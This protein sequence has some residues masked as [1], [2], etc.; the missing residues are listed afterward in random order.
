MLFRTVILDGIRK[1]TV[2][3]AFRRWKRPTVKPGGSLKTAAGVLA[4]AAVE[5]IREDEINEEDARRA[6]AASRADL[7]AEL[8]KSGSGTLYRI[9]FRR[10]GDDPRLALREDDGLDHAAIAGL[11]T[12]LASLDRAMPWTMR[13]LILIGDHP[14]RPAA[15]LAVELGFGKLAAKRKIRALKELGLTESLDVG[16]RLSPRGKAFLNA[17]GATIC[18]NE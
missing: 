9:A 6:G 5:T 11:R 18:T 4:I 17:L 3:L 10:A 14:G 7:L 2:T 13:T 8:S 16:Y 15:E 1:G 12:R